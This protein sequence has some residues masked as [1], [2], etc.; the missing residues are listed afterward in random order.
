MLSS[1]WDLPLSF[2]TRNNFFLH[3]IYCCFSTQLCFKVS[4]FSG[5]LWKLC[6]PIIVS[7]LAYIFRNAENTDVADET[8]TPPHLLHS[9]NTTT[10]CLYAYVKEYLNIKPI[11]LTPCLYFKNNP[12]WNSDFCYSQACKFLSSEVKLVHI[13]HVFY[14]SYKASWSNQGIEVKYKAFSLAARLLAARSLIT[15][16]LLM[17]MFLWK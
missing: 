12:K 15:E 10:W 2:I 8:C 3:Y 11:I 7:K 6:F 4:I 16:C 1:C 13:V 17:I 5:V 9:E 14:H